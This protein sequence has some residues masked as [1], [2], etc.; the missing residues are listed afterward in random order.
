MGEGGKIVLGDDGMV[1]V[2]SG[3]LRTASL[4]TL[5]HQKRGWQMS[6]VSASAW[7]QAIEPPTYRV[8]QHFLYFFALPQG[9]GAL[10]PTF[11]RLLAPMAAAGRMAVLGQ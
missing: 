1:W 4:V 11:L 2:E 5:V 7:R 8:I 3:R 9:H 6:D 10:G